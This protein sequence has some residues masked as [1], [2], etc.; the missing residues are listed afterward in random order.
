MKSSL[1]TI[2]YFIAFLSYCYAERLKLKQADVLE[3]KRIG[4]ETV[5]ILEGNIEF[6]KGN[7]ELKCQNSIY[8]EKKDIAYLYDDVKMN[9]EDINLTCDSITFFSKNNKLESTG[10]P[11]IQDTEYRLTANKL[12]YFTDLDSGIA[13][14]NVE[15]L[16]NNQSIKADKIEYRKKSNAVSYLATGNVKIIDSLRT[17][18]C[19][20][21]SYDASN[22]KTILNLKPKIINEDRAINGDQ[23]ILNYDNDVL[24]RIF[25]PKNANISSISEGYGQANHDSSKT[26][27]NFDDRMN[28]KSLNGFFINGNLDSLRLVG[29][30][31]TTYHIFEDSLYK[32]KNITSGDTIIMRFVEK[33]LN[34]IIVSGGSQG[35]YVPN[36]KTNDSKYPLVYSADKIDYFLKTENT[37][38]IGNANAHHE[39]TELKAGF[40]KVNWPTKI[41]TAF[42]RQMHDSTG[43][44]I[45]PTIVEKGKDPMV[46]SEMTYN[47]DTKK[48]KINY[49]RTKADDGFY[50]GKEIRNE[51]NE[52]IYIKNSIFTTCDLD[53][54]HFHFESDKMKIIRDDVVIA[55]P[56][57]LKISEIPIFGIPLAIFPHQGGR[58]HSGWIMPAYGE[59]KSRGQYIDGLGYYWA[60]NDYWD[61]KFTL[62][63]GD[64]QGAVLNVKNQYRLRYKYNGN[65]FIRNQQFLSGSKDI[66]SLKENRNSNFMVRWNHS[67][68]LRNN[69]TFNAN[70]TYSSNGN[71]NRDYGLN[72][73]QRMDQKATSNVTYSKRW[74]KSK[75]S[76]SINLYSN[77]DLLVEKKVDSSS[78]YYVSPTHSGSQLNIS[79]RTLPKISFRRGQSSL[80]PTL[81]N[82]N[83]WYS[84]IKWNYGFNYT[85]KE[86]KYYQSTYSDALGSYNWERDEN[87]NPID[88]LF[89]DAGWTHTSSLNAPMKL[90]K[91]INVNPN[92]NFKSNWVNRYFQKTWIDSTSSFQNI[93]QTGFKTRT[94]G[95]VSLNANTKLYGLF[96]IPFGP[97]KVIR[98]VASPSI[99]FSWS[100]DF[101]EPLFGYDFGYFDD[102]QN[103]LNGEVVKHDKFA[104]TMAGSTPSNEQK[105]INFS[106][107]NI[108]QAKSLVK[109]EVKKIDLFSLRM[110]SSYNFSAEKYKLS[111]LR[112]SLRSKIFGK[113]NIDLSTTHDFYGY[114]SQTGARVEKFQKNRQGIISPRL[115]NARLS[116]GFRLN[117]KFKNDSEEDLS[118]STDSSGVENDLD[119]PGLENPINSFKN[120]IKSGNIWSTNISLSYSYSAYNPLN[121]NKTFW[122]NTSSN[123][124]LSKNW[125]IAYRARFDMVKRDLVSHNISVNR[126]LHCWELSL[127]WTP[128]GIGQG[129]YFRLNVKSPTLKD[130][131]LEK[132]GGVYSSSPF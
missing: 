106:I 51:S 23:I 88:T 20:L 109:E 97:I 61:S 50:K 12:I 16:Q 21:A 41:L 3:S 59:S 71:Y 90:F 124:N 5:K 58:R 126:D 121:T 94:T 79:N 19:G 26:V 49:G 67:Q 80:F 35:E 101:S 77:Q 120:S 84:N 91:H 34:D 115:T 95:S 81:A 99:G 130:L 63:F 36:P 57:T 11:V 32:G 18:T 6:Q 8:K 13:V 103:P 43:Q 108:F 9:K 42:P 112:S 93:E 55:K 48:G 82:K 114:D 25:I 62:S 116:T 119:G 52:T 102:Y 129:V 100:P 65:L 39:N 37:K 64:R 54:P 131:K 87:G 85:K 46:G 2:I 118:S 14:G 40:I 125:K 105:N 78:N 72:L 31:S 68:K 24:K 28:S 53:T 38:L 127:N 111:N 76:I 96:A 30:A 104:G 22:E 1:K 66:I 83:R 7:I 27:L 122:I 29:M 73:A 17:A 56:I 117:G 44:F 4:F 69:Q 70:T 89:Q 75:N 10:S 45:K 74:I 132:K 92:I 110:S 128:G 113:L 15:L 123:I 98:H 33:D 47:L 107:N 60:P 86:R